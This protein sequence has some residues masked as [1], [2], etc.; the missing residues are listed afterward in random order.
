MLTALRNMKKNKLS[1]DL[2][3]LLDRIRDKYRNPTQH[4]ELK[5]TIDEAQDLLGVCIEA[6][7]KTMKEI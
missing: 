2:L 1:S 3:D 6:I 7:N 4:P 5:Y